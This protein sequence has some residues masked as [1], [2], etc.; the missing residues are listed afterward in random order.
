MIDL[1]S[2]EAITRAAYTIFEVLR[3]NDDI[4][5]TKAELRNYCN[6]HDIDAQLFGRG[7]TWLTFQLGVIIETSYLRDPSG[8]GRSSQRNVTL[9][10][11]NLHSD[12]LRCKDFHT[13]AAPSTNRA[14]A[15]LKGHTRATGHVEVNSTSVDGWR[16]RLDSTG[17]TLNGPTAPR[18]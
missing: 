17:V 13:E 3:A 2:P 15:P 12:A 6:E 4:S 14:V 10:E 18:P 11:R 1:P 5:A 7:F 16:V 8:S 9:L